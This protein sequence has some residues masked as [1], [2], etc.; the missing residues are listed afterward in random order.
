MQNF[1]IDLSD[2]LVLQLL[3]MEAQEFKADYMV[4]E[5]FLEVQVRP[6]SKLT[7]DVKQLVQLLINF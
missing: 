1:L 6:G 4:R 7:I 2:L 3:I 5:T